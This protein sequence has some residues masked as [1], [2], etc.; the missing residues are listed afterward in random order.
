MKP[1]IEPIGL[2]DLNVVK[3]ELIGFEPGDIA[4]I[5]NVMAFETRSREHR[6]FRR[7]E[8]ILTEE[9]E[10]SEENLHEM[11]S[12]ERFQIEQQA[13]E[14]IRSETKFEAGAEISAGFGPVQIGAYARFSTNQ[15][16]E[17]TTTYSTNYAKDIIERSLNRIIERV[18][19][20]RI[21]KTLEE[22]EETNKHGFENTEG[23][24]QS[25]I[26]RW[27]NK[28]YRAK[29]V[30]YGKRL[31]FRFILPWPASFYIFAQQNH[32]E[33]HVM[34]D[35]PEKPVHPEN[36][37]QLLQ[38]GHIQRDNYRTLVTQYGAD[39]IKAPPPEFITLIKSIARDVDPELDFAIVD[40]DLE[41]PDGY[42]I[43]D[44][45]P[46]EMNFRRQL[47]D[48]YILTCAGRRAL[49][50]GADEGRSAFGDKPVDA[51]GVL[52]IVVRGHGIHSF[53]VVTEIVCKLRS[54][55][56][57]AWQLETFRAIMNAY[58][59]EKQAYDERVAAA[60]IEQGVKISGK[61]PK[62]NRE[63]IIE[64][65]Q[66]ACI[67]LWT[68]F[69]FNGVPMISHNQDADIPDNFPQIHIEN[70][71]EMTPEISFLHEAFDWF[72]MT[73]EFYPYIWAERKHWLD[74]FPL[75]DNDPLF[76]DFLRAGA[77]RVL[78]PVHL[79]ATETVLYYQLTG[80][81]QHDGDI[82]LF[83]TPEPGDTFTTNTFGGDDNDP[84]TE[85]ELYNAYIDELR[86]DGITNNIDK[87]VDISPD[88]PDTWI[89]EEPTSLVWLQS[90][91]ELPPIEE[92]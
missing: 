14:V 79:E 66:K 49:F 11:E 68:G 70:T 82:P 44:L 67:T 38:P 73:F 13:Q 50:E 64:E 34:P 25:G 24:H 80:K 56:F 83:E 76:N 19:S 57:E 4:H 54:E 53:I 17:Q 41:I 29:V 32:L 20:E 27:V 55:A 10:R 89:I 85:L 46:R 9:F 86:A 48:Y 21:T 6:R 42:V 90:D 12:T 18:R 51:S 84:E 47:D 60:Q 65:L 7:V 28:Y 77:A 23:Q 74:I 35:E 59:K 40:N 2:G 5:E 36:F 15:S 75:E 43:Y 81:L 71:L 58:N 52:P 33:N 45:K 88:D 62:I 78:V 63:I 39:G 16:K 37:R 1:K 22:F 87:D 69:Q 31:W 91:S 3:M 8:E 92:S 26:Y 61:N 72:N 30:K